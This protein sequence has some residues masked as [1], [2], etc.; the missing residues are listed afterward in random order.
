[1][2]TC[3]FGWTLVGFDKDR[4]EGDGMR[5]LLM[6]VAA[7][8]SLMAAGT[9]A[10]ADAAE[11][12]AQKNGCMACHSVQQKVLGPA[13]KDVAAKY[14]GDKTAETKL[15]DRVKKGGSGVWGPIPMPAN[16]PQVKDEDIK[17]IIQWVLKR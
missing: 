8:G 10:A 14:K 5:A 3:C 13:F 17:T 15:I 16:S 11:A 9:V 12:L 1:M 6:T 4:I 7:A 2:I